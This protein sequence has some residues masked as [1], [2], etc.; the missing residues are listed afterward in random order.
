MDCVFRK[1]II[2]TKPRVFICKIYGLALLYIEQH[3]D[4]LRKKTLQM[5]ENVLS[6]YVPGLEY[7]RRNGDISIVADTLAPRIAK[8]S[9]LT[10]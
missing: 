7:S 2:S 1:P 5:I 4:N 8:S 6:D 9:V 3:S 10:K